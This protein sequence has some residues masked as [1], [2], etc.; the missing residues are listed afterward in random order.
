MPTEWPI[1]TAISCDHHQSRVFLMSC[2]RMAPF[3]APSEDALKLRRKHLDLALWP[4]VK[5]IEI[6]THGRADETREIH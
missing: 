2:S 4:I 3:S 1:C 5:Y 6:E